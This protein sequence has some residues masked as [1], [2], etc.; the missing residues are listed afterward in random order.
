PCLRNAAWS[1]SVPEME[2]PLFFTKNPF[3]FAALF[4]P[5]RQQPSP[6]KRRAAKRWTVALAVAA[7]VASLVSLSAV[8]AAS[9][10]SAPLNL[11]G[12]AGD[13]K[14]T[15]AWQPP[16][17]NGGS[18]ILGYNIFKDG[19]FLLS[20]NVVL[21]YTV[22]GL[23]NG[24]TYRFSVSA[25]NAY[26]GGAHSSLAYVSPKAATTTGRRRPAGQGMPV[27]APP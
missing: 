22:T 9:A 23:T 11:T 7:N 18:S 16:T 6:T 20:T 21:T 4:Q 8:T 27:G 25:Y 24:V 5:N 3:R 13:S 1:R 17:S 15:L 14:A 26:G 10:P 12:V 19:S 2:G